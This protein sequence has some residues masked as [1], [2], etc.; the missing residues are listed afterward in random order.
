[1]EWRH[2]KILVTGTTGF[3]GSHLTDALH[4]LN[5]QLIVGIDLVNPHRSYF[6]SQQLASKIFFIQEDVRNF[7]AMVEIIIKY[8]IDTIFHLAAQPI[9]DTAYKLPLATLTTN[10]IGTANILEA[11]RIKGNCQTI[12]VASSDKAYGPSKRLPYTETQQ[13]KGT[14]PYDVSKTSTDLIAQMYYKTYGLPVIITR[15]GNIFGAGDPNLNRIIP[16]IFESIIKKKELLIRSDGTMIRDYVYVKEVVDGYIKLAEHTG[17]IKGEAFNFGSK[18]IFSVRQV[19]KKIEK[20]LDVKVDHKILN[21]AKNEIDRQYLDWTKAK[22][23]LQWQPQTNFA[24]AIKE[25]FEWYK[26]F[27]FK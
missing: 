1:M 8:D 22:K 27:Y 14:H 18:N 13:L 23:I 2:T 11:A 16:G 15:F 10:I 5:P 4:Q 3:V 20:I 9:V 21:I 26:N 12:I 19:I 25:S 7:D 6:S 17:E 24:T